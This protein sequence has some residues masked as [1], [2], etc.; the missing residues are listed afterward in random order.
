[1]ASRDDGNFFLR[2]TGRQPDENWMGSRH[3]RPIWMDKES[4]YTVD[5]GRETMED[6]FASL[7]S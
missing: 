5:S 4:R 3:D 7:P 6:Q 2:R 1:M